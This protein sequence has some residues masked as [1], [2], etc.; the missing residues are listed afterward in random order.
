MNVY[1]CEFWRD[2]NWGVALA[3]SESFDEVQSI[4]KIWNSNII[5]MQGPSLWEHIVRTIKLDCTAPAKGVIYFAHGTGA[6]KEG[7][8]CRA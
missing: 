3:A 5:S 8:L 7:A 4:I 6:F 1:A 2:D